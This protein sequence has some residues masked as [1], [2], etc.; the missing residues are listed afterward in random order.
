MINTKKAVIATLFF[1]A[2]SFGYAQ[3]TTMPSDSAKVE[4]AQTQTASA[5]PE[6]DTLKKQVATNA[7]DTAALVKLATA[8]QDAKD[9]PNALATWKNISTLLPDWAPG[10]YS[11]GYVYQ[12]MKDDANAKTAYEK[13]ITSVKPEEL[14]ANK[15]NLAYAEFFVA[16]N[17]KDTDKESAKQHIAKSLEYDPM[18][19]DAT[20]LKTFLNQ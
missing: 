18:N 2:V 9:L 3:T 4:T 7:N 13:Y 20:K 5:N 12:S 19:A 16:Y 14:E 17:L 15:K 6:I 11:Q 10:Y 8:Y 1:G